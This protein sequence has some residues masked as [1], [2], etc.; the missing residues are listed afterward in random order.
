MRGRATSAALLALVCALTAALS[1]GGEALASGERAAAPAKVSVGFAG[2]AQSQIL[3]KGLRVRLS[4]K[5]R[6]GA[7]RPAR[8]RIRATSATFDAPG[9]TKLTRPKTVKA[10]RSG[11]RI[12]RL[13]LTPAG[14]KAVASCE[15]RRLRVRASRARG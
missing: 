9:F 8:V 4:V 14:R 1:A 12:V 5:L 2:L 11:K 3:A 10:R 15:A 6:R 13:Q 7:R